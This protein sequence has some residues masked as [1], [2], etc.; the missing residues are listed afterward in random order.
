MLKVSRKAADLFNVTY[1][2]KFAMIKAQYWIPRPPHL[3]A[4][5]RSPYL[6]PVVP[7]AELHLTLAEALLEVQML[8]EGR[9]PGL[10]VLGWQRRHCSLELRY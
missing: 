7:A 8:L 4:A 6:L 10:P 9:M 3:P 5:L 2:Y 1:P